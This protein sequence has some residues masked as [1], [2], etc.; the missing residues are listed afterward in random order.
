MR[1]VIP[2]V[3]WIGNAFNARNIKGVMDAGF[4]V[5]IDLA[6]E[7]PPIQLPRDM[8]YCRFPLLDGEGN[9]PALMKS[10]INL[11]VSF[12][13][14]QIP[15]LVACSGGMSR[16]PLIASAVLAMVDGIDLDEAIRRVTATGPCDFSPNLYNDVR[17]LLKRSN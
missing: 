9:S 17:K 16:S 12:V 4:Q 6:A 13:Q 14:A 10:A 11:I 15:T 2:N 3:L 7:E 1:E 5:V 8:I